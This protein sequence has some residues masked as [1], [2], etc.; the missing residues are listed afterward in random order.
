MENELVKRYNFSHALAMV[1]G[2]VIGAGI[3]FKGSKGL[4]NGT[5]ANVL[6]FCSNSYGNWNLFLQKR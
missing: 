6:G 2:I 5:N 1:V 3:F 4:W